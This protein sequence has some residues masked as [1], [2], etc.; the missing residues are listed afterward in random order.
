MT[1][2]KNR[3]NKKCARIWRLEP[4]YIASR[5]IN[6]DASMENSLA[7]SQKVKL[8]FCLVIL[9]LSIYPREMKHYVHKSLYTDVRNS[10]I[11]NSQR[12]KKKTQLSIRINKMWYTHTKDSH[13]GGS[14]VRTRLSIQEMQETWV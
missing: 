14:M 12:V 10:I 5:S 11:H 3:N 2:I 6:S 8:P 9:P 13:P 1:V 7:F 4:A